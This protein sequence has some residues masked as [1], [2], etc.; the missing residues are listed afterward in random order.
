MGC[1]YGDGPAHP[2]ALSLQTIHLAAGTY[3][4]SQSNHSSSLDTDAIYGYDEFRDPVKAK[5]CL[6]PSSSSSSSSS[7]HPLFPLLALIFEKC[8]LATC[9]PRESGAGGGDVCSSNSFSEDIAVF[10]RQVK[11]PNPSSN[12][13]Y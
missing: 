3:Q 11:V 13:N 12:Q 4:F 9:T 2:A 8:E 6:C 1:V 7:R 5:D 10:S